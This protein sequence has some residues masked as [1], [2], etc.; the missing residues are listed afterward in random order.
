MMRIEYFEN[1]IDESNMNKIMLDGGIVR[2]HPSGG[3][4]LNGCTCSPGHWITVLEP[5]R[6]GKVRGTRFTFDSRSELEEVDGGN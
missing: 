6:D 4:G 5:C 3:C 1:K 2:S